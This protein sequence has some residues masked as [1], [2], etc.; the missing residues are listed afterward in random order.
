[1]SAFVAFRG[2]GTRAHRGERAHRVPRIAPLL[3]E[4]LQDAAFRDD[5][6]RHEFESAVE[7][8]IDEPGIP[9]SEYLGVLSRSWTENEVYGLLPFGPE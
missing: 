9:G 1:M 6:P 8:P 3:L 4:T 5:T 2:I 7:V